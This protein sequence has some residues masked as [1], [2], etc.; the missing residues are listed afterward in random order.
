MGWSW[1]CAVKQARVRCFNYYYREGG[2]IKGNYNTTYSE[3]VKHV[4]YV[5]NVSSLLYT[6][7]RPLSGQELWQVWMNKAFVLRRFRKI[8]GSDYY[9]RQV[10]L[11]VCPYAWNNS[12]PTGWIFMKFELP[13]FFFETLSKKI[14]MELKSDKNNATLHT[15]ILTVIIVSHSVLIKI[16]NLANKVCR[17]NQNTF[18]VK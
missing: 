1:F 12:P 13:V 11:A 9:L 2:G 16:R 6:S 18:H 14:R 10:C 7:N 8:A 3:I 15:D 17:E 4:T 5:R